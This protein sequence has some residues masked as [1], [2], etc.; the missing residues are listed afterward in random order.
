VRVGPPGAHSGLLHGELMGG[1]WGHKSS[2]MGLGP[3]E[4]KM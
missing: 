4:Q 2:G 3:Q 1:S